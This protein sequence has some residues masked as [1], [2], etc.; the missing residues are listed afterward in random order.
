MKTELYCWFF[1]VGHRLT[2]TLQGVKYGCWV[3]NLGEVSFVTEPVFLLVIRHPGLSNVQALNLPMNKVCMCVLME[4]ILHVMQCQAMD[5]Y[6]LSWLSILLMND[7]H[8]CALCCLC[9]LQVIVVYAL[10]YQNCYLL[11][12]NYCLSLFGICCT[13]MYAQTYVY[14]C[15]FYIWNILRLA[16]T[17]LMMLTD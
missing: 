2:I 6:G 12:G 3:Y 7:L 4:C 13:I 17:L 10:R 14:H 9:S 5:Q 1:L 8:L 16:S 11:G 15:V